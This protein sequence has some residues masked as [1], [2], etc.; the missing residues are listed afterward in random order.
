MMLARIVSSQGRRL[1]V[2]NHTDN[3]SY[4]DVV[5]KIS[6]EQFLEG[7]WPKMQEFQVMD[8]LKKQFEPFLEVAMQI[9]YNALVLDD[10]GMAFHANCTPLEVDFFGTAKNN[11]ND[12]FYQM[13]HFN[14]APPKLL[15]GMD[16]IV[17]KETDDNLPLQN[18][19]PHRRIIGRLL[20]NIRRKNDLMPDD[21]RWNEYILDMQ[22]STIYEMAL[23][24]KVT[25][26]LKFRDFL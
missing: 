10:A 22:N 21:Q 13:H 12:I 17:L 16:M 1:I 19:V 24:G 7:R 6:V 3:D 23:D 25:K 14:Q 4:S 15:L 5:K 9:K 26:S 18:K 11:H 20:E 2:Y 8:Y